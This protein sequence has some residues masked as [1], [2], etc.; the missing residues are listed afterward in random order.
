MAVKLTLVP[1]EAELREDGL[2]SFAPER[3]LRR[4]GDRHEPVAVGRDFDWLSDAALK[5]RIDLRVAISLVLERRLALRDLD[6]AGV[7]ND[8]I[9]Q[10]NREAEGTRPEAPLWSASADYLRSL[11]VSRSA[12][13]RSVDSVPVPT[14]LR[15]RLA[16]VW[17]LQATDEPNELS[18][19]IRWEIA[20]VA[21][22]MTMSEWAFRTALKVENEL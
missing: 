8:L 16:R 2:E 4:P 12:E 6:S 14:R 9:A 3:V 22:G 10:L 1:A 11:L 15:E 21:Q 5:Q 17:P 13:T 7:K 20:A 18:A 19:A